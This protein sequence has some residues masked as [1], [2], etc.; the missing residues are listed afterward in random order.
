MADNSKITKKQ[1]NAAMTKVKAYADSLTLGG[2]GS[3]GGTGGVDL[4]GYV[5]KAELNE[6][7]PLVKTISS[8]LWTTNTIDEYTETYSYQ[9]T[10]N[11]NT[12]DIIV[13]FYDNELENLYCAFKIIDTNNILITNDEAIDM[14]VVIIHGG[15]NTDVSRGG[16]SIVNSYTDQTWTFI[17]DSITAGI[18]TTKTYHDFLK[19]KLSLGTIINLGVNG[20]ILS[21]TMA[22]DIKTASTSTNAIFVF[23]G[24]NDFNAGKA[25]GEYYTVDDSGKKT[26]NTDINT[27]RGALISICTTMHDRFA[28]CKCYLMT[29]IHR[30]KYPSQ[31]TDL[32]K[33]SA[34]LYLDDYVE[35]IKEVGKIMSIP[36]IDLFALSGLQPNIASNKANY[37]SSNDGLHPSATGHE[38]ICDC[39][40]NNL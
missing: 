12:N 33:N 18:G 5:T 30:E 27:F 37:F 10:H 6:Y 29:P 23:G 35:S 39:I 13:N 19:E 1:L 2:S 11:L 40:I 31:P 3:T 32:E 16:N 17:G 9:L 21:P 22:N 24:T 36:V 14:T 4:S 38:K 26:L 7:T 34:G 28:N 20:K 8:N 15:V 25:L